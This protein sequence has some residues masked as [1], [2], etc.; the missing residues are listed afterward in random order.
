MSE[1][2]DFA[3]VLRQHLDALAAADD[4]CRAAADA[5]RTV[6]RAAASDGINVALFKILFKEKTLDP[7]ILG[8]LQDYRAAAVDW[9]RTPLA[10]AAVHFGHLGPPPPLAEA[11]Q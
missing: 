1:L 9:Q 2:R 11:A 8:E 6:L 4:A 10:E 7:E 5:K 3:E